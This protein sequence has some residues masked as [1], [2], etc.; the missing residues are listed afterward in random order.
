MN[1]R[2][3][4]EDD[5]E[6]LHALWDEFAG[7]GPL[8]PWAADAREASQAGIAEALREGA[9][10]IAEA[11]GQPAGFACGRVRNGVLA[12]I[13]ELYVRPDSRRRGVA[14]RLLRTVVEDL[15]ARGVRFV[16]VD[17][18][19]DNAP[20]RTLYERA[21]FRPES[22]RLIAE[23]AE[24]ERGL[25]EATAGPSFG[26]IH[27]QTDDLAAVERAVREFV[28][29]LPGRSRGSIVA[30]PANGWVAVYDDVCDR[31][32]RQL[33]RLARELSDRLGAVVIALGVEDDAVVRFILLDRGSEV[34]EY[35]SVPEYHGSLPPGDVVALAANPRVVTRLTGADPAA[36]RA[37]A[38]QAASPAELPPPAELLA[39]IAAVVGIHGAGHGW[40]DARDV[41]GA[42]RIDRT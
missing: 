14:R 32:A 2:R 24:L 31:D 3:A 22:L 12:E 28:P 17:T 27:V 6:L 25:E 41:A 11:D 15:R 1:I 8:P 34:D 37:V 23:A 10:A 40:A 36:V 19:P 20:A 35:L 16:A 26:S 9:A 39:A 21:G 38:R 42:V 29:R 7:P 5:R 4:T 13:T 30:P 33:R 18:A